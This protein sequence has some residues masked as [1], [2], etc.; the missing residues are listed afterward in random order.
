MSIA[1]GIFVLVTVLDI[2]IAGLIMGGIYALI[3]VGLSLQYGVG[4]VLNVSHGEF[5][6]LGAFATW[7][8]YTVFGISPL[9]SLV[10]CGPVLFIIAFLIHR[11]L[12]QY[13]RDTSESIDVFEGNSLLASFGL[14][15]II[16][17][18]ALLIWKANVRGYTY[19]VYSVNLGGAVFT[20]NRL[21]AL[22]FAVVLSLAFYIFLTRARLGKAIRAAAEEPEMA[23]LMGVN[24]KRV[25]AICFGLG[26]LMA[27]FAGVLV[28]MLYQMQPTMGLE[29]TIIAVIVVVLGGLG[30]ITGSLIG[31]FILGLIGSIVTY[32]D[33]A[34]SL[35]AYYVIFILLLLVKPTGILGK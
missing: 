13:L 15:F 2:V 4:R 23:G 30:S 12:F 7:S 26:A 3:A 29:Y 14:L 18:V 6:M 17:N 24:I 28:S 21:I 32:F 9:I 22:L 25:L 19:L 1:E 34:L 27:G 10:I 5:I 16:Q 8:L 33:P 20:V 35:V 31:G 11:T